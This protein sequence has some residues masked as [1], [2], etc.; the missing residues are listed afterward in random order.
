ML[1][2]FLNFLECQI[3]VDKFEVDIHFFTDFDSL[4]E[5]NGIGFNGLIELFE[6]IIDFCLAEDSI[7]DL[8]FTKILFCVFDFVLDLSN[9]FFKSFLYIHI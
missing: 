3:N 2:D 1:F 9:S 8:G 4:F 6:L 7:S 5:G